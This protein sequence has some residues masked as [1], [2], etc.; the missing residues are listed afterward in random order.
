MS[1][2]LQN[3]LLCTQEPLSPLPKPLPPLPVPKRATSAKVETDS[4]EEVTKKLSAQTLV[5]REP[6]ISTKELPKNP[7]LHSSKQSTKKTMSIKKLCNSYKY[8]NV[9][10]VTIGV[11]YMPGDKVRDSNGNVCT[12]HFA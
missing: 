11:A 6:T 4:V 9:Q 10:P 8:R 1:V 12:I 7:D 5:D 3:T 2:V